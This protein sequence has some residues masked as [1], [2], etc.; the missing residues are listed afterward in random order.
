MKS[1]FMSLSDRCI[2][3]T[4]RLEENIPNEHPGALLL[5]SHT[6]QDVV[7]SLF[8]YRR[9]PGLRHMPANLITRQPLLKG[10]LR[11]LIASVSVFFPPPPCLLYFAPIFFYVITGHTAERQSV[12]L[13]RDALEIFGMCSFSPL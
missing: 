10:G 13:Y 4:T 11:A 2:T 6:W 5:L 8:V 7:D 12:I 1:T 9:Y 3:R